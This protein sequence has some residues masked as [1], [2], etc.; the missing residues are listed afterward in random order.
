MK[1]L[2]TSLNAK[3]E[4]PDDQTILQ[5]KKM[6]NKRIESSKKRLLDK[7]SE[8][9][10]YLEKVHYDYNELIR[11][12][13][14]LGK[15]KL[16]F[17]KDLSDYTNTKEKDEDKIFEYEEVKVDGEEVCDDLLHCI[18]VVKQ[19]SAEEERKK[20]GQHQMEIERLELEE[21]KRRI[22]MEEKI[23]WKNYILKR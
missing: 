22:S 16:Q 14:Q 12:R 15:K 10:K 23:V 6:A 19:S 7:I 20:E 11:L 17:E 18:D 4:I 2:G 8:G 3:E 1:Y 9:R 21:R 5:T 13:N